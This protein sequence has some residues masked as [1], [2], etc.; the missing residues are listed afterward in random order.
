MQSVCLGTVGF[1]GFSRAWKL[2]WNNS[3]SFLSLS[4]NF[5]VVIKGISLIGTVKGL[6]KGGELFLGAFFILEN[7]IE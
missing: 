5:E 6:T 4:P 2:F 1:S 3:I 7:S